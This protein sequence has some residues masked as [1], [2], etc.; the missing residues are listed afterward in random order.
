MSCEKKSRLEFKRKFQRQEILQIREK[1][2]NF[3]FL[4]RSGYVNNFPPFLQKHIGLYK[5]VKFT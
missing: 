1:N 2:Y 5:K 4:A 3:S